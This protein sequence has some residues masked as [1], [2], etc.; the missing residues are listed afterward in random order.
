MHQNVKDVLD[1][2][3]MEGLMKLT[4]QHLL[5]IKIKIESLITQREGMIAFNQGLIGMDSMKYNEDAFLQL[6]A[7]FDL[8]Y[9]NLV[10]LGEQ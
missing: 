5:E 1:N 4:E 9:E 3:K 10:R 2:N 7:Q 8:L 6:R